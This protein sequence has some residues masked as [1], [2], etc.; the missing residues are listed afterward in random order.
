[1]SKTQPKTKKPRKRYET[2]NQIRDDIARYKIKAEKLRQTAF[3]LDVEADRLS[4]T[5][6]AENNRGLIGFK[7]SQ[8]DKCRR[9]ADRIETK[10]MTLLKQKMAEFMTDP[11]P[12]LA[13][14][15]IP[16]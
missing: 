10:K 9:S 1:M 14:R 8:A 15:D 16:R 11:L 3:D 5:E 4:R 12:G 2:A 7:R 6:Y 13:G